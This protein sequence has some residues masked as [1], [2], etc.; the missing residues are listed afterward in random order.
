LTGITGVASNEANST[1]TVSEANSALT[2]SLSALVDSSFLA[3]NPTLAFSNWA[4]GFSTLVPN[5]DETNFTDAIVARP[6]RQNKA[7]QIV[8]I[9]GVHP[10]SFESYGCVD[11]AV[12]WGFDDFNRWSARLCFVPAV[13]GELI[14]TEQFSWLSPHFSPQL[15]IDPALGASPGNKFF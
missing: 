10:D 8:L 5:A 9:I 7:S 13:F 1:L 15:P 4:L 14:R 12:H 6:A 2:V 3:F 11:T